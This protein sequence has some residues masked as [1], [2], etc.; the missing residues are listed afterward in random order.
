MLWV[1]V[2][3]LLGACNNAANN[4]EV[5]NYS[6]E[7]ETKNLFSELPV[8]SIIAADSTPVTEDKL[9]HFYFSVR[10]KTTDKTKYGTYLI[11]AVYGANTAE[12]EFTLPK[13]GEYLKPVLKKGSKPYSY[14]VGF[15]FQNKFHEYYEVKGGKSIISINPLKAIIMYKG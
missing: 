4:A 5:L 14:I 13:G 3:M 15:F 12:S 2:V 1:I 10:I 8:N 9:N 11:E 6:T 7:N